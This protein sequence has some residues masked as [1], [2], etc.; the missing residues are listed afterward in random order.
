MWAHRKAEQVN[1]SVFMCR[2]CGYVEDVDLNAARNIRW[3]AAV[4]QP[5]DC[6]PCGAELG[7]FTEVHIASFI[8][9]VILIY[10]CSRLPSC[11]RAH[12]LR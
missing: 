4:N 9:S 10:Q 12:V 2:S 11:T 7:G 5:M 6:D 3:R 8:Y 1:Q